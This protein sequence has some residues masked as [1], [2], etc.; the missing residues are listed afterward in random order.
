M[1]FARALFGSQAGPCRHIVALLALSALL[2][3][4][5]PVSASSC[6]GTTVDLRD[7]GY[8][9]WGYSLTNTR[10][11]ANTRLT[12]DN[13]STLKLKWVASLGKHADHHSMPFVTADTVFVGTEDGSLLALDR[14]T[15]CER[16]VRQFD[17]SIR[18]AIVDYSVTLKGKTE[19]LL[20]FGTDTGSVYAITAADGEVVWRVA[21]DVHKNTR[22]TSTPAIHDNTV[23]I[24]VSST[25]AGSAAGPTYSCCTFRGSIL[26]VDATTGERRWRSYSID[27]PARITGTR[28]LLIKERG[29]SGAPIWSTPTIDT[30]R[31]TVYYGTGENYSLPATATSDAIIAIAQSDGS[32]RW[33][34]QFTAGDVWNISCDIPLISS[35]CP[36]KSKGVDLDFGAPPILTVSKAHGPILVAGQK[37]GVVYAMQPDTG[38]VL[39]S[40]RVGRGG[41]LG[42]I[43]WGM[44]VSESSNLLFVPISD[45]FGDKHSPDPARPG[46]HA[47]DLDTGNIVWSTLHMG[48]CT[49]DGACES[50]LSAAITASPGL[51]FSGGLD[52][53]LRAYDADT[54]K[55]L[56]TFATATDMT[57]VG[58]HRVR[59]GAIDVH[60]P[61]VVD[62]MLFVTSGYGAFLQQS[63]NAFLA[64]ELDQ[65]D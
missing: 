19:L 63:G 45:R 39:W 29:P 44:A 42:G 26:A 65:G 40:Q 24:P 60:G 27:E 34:R 17:A 54:G 37:S 53:I 21:A 33:S 47:L 16:F 30:E 41:K 49:S 8:S 13:V 10:F 5:G 20:Y 7:V 25:E 28:L 38:Q 9:G 58:G 48:G 46:L 14:Q 23:Y 6:D 62:D 50:G 59:G 11:Q 15:G 51:V 64:F 2:G 22:I 36:D 31:G 61:V 43:H 56:W 3:L 4:A 12:K 1:P 55:V 35:N 52:G 32:R 18:T 57:A